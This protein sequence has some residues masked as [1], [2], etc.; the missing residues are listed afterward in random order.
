MTLPDFSTCDENLL[1]RYLDDDLD[2]DEKTQMTAHVAACRL[3]G[4]QLAALTAISDDLRNRVEHIAD[5]VD[6][7][8][9]EKQV[10]NK[11]IRQHRSRGGFAR[12]V[13]S[14]KYTLPVTAAA[15]LLLFF[16][17]SNYVIKPPP[18]P[19][20]II[21][22]FKGSM[23]S[24]MIFETPDTRQTILWYTEEPDVKNEPNTI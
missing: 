19:S 7:V 23:S 9:L 10:L 20:A 1:N 21:S 4:R 22:S 11:A 2:A 5:S 17:Y 8:G 15:G 3:C 12:F 14:L 18:V 16:A 24:V 13:A 6:F